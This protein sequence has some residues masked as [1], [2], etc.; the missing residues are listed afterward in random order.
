VHIKGAFHFLNR[1]ATNDRESGSFEVS[2][3]NIAYSDKD[4]RQTEGEA[5]GEKDEAAAGAKRFDHVLRHEVG[6][7][8]DDT[9][10][11]HST[12]GGTDQGAGWKEMEPRAMVEEMVASSG[13]GIHKLPAPERTK[14]IELLVEVAVGKADLEEGAA[15]RGLDFSL[16]YADH[17]ARAVLYGVPEVDPWK[18][19]DGGV[20]LNAFIYLQTKYG[21]GNKWWRYPVAARARKVSTYQ[22][23]SPHEWFAEL[24]A[25]YYAPSKPKGE[26]LRQRDE[27]A[28]RFFTDNV[29]KGKKQGE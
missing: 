14:A 8:V 7:A 1:E 4:R 13:G 25:T 5:T 23:K 21:D 29:D 28:F 18:L 24:Y 20:N 26:L 2:Q 6:H 11:Y 17:A 27:G 3:I 15:A 19:D 22:F 12:F 16:L 10:D 9:F